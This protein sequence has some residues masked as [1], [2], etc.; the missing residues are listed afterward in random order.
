M[1]LIRNNIVTTADVNLATKVFG[2][3]IGSI[4]VKTTRRKPTPVVSNI[5]EIP[6]ELLE[7]QKDLTLSLDGMT[8]NSLKFL[9]TI[10]HDLMYRT[11]QYVQRN[12]AMNYESCMDEIMAVYNRGLFTITEIHCDNEF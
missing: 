9:T 12:N 4:K 10:S 1:N 2:P 5:I 3:D 11:A 8:I 6:D 7:L